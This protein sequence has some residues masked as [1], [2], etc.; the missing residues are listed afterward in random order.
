MRDLLRKLLPPCS[1]KKIIAENEKY[2]KK[3]LLIP[4]VSTIVDALACFVLGLVFAIDNDE[5]FW[6]WIFWGGGSIFCYL[7]Y[8]CLKILF[9]YPILHIFYLKS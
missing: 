6:I 3:I 7:N 9:S 5:F 8:Y 2:F 1:D 4:I